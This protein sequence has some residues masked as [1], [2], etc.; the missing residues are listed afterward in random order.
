M[1]T[2]LYATEAI[3]LWCID[4]NQWAFFDVCV[5]V[6]CMQMYVLYSLAFSPFQNAGGILWLLT[7]PWRWYYSRNIAG[8]YNSSDVESQSDI[9]TWSIAN[10]VLT[11]ALFCRQRSL[12]SPPGMLLPHNLMYE[13]IFFIKGN[14]GKWGHFP[15]MIDAECNHCCTFYSTMPVELIPSLFCP[16]LNNVVWSVDV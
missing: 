9:W 12:Y 8:I 6:W 10:F 13:Y 3:P 2:K 16:S 11:Q 4:M 5:C 15:R 7:V 1:R 14:D